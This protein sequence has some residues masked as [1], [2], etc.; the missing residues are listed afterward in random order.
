M[1][2]Y[3]LGNIR[4]I[5]KEMRIFFF[6]KHKSQKAIDSGRPTL[7]AAA[8]LSY[9]LAFFGRARL[10]IDR[11]SRAS[12]KVSLPRK[13]IREN[14]VHTFQ[15]KKKKKKTHEIERLRGDF[16]MFTRKHFRKTIQAKRKDEIDQL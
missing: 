8:L 5:A 2:E 7:T 9:L 6:L 3:F 11:S 12:D 16:K 1:S 4:R 13:S 15:K 10:W 14:R